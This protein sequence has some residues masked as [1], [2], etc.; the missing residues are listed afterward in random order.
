MAQA[1]RRRPAEA[2]RLL[3]Q[4]AG[5]GCCACGHP[6]LQYHHIVPYTDD[7]PHYRPQDMMVLCPN[8][9]DRATQGVLDE[10]S[11]RHLKAHPHN[12]ERGLAGGQ[13]TV[14]QDRPEIVIGESVGMIGEGGLIELDGEALLSLGLSPE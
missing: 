5:Y 12:I 7:D 4:E 8:C 11:Q 6:I 2:T 3:R 9:H 13:L 10:R 14:V 1:R